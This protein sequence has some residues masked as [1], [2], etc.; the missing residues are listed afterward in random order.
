VKVLA[1]VTDYD[2]LHAVLRARK[3]ALDISCNTI[4][5]AACLTAA[6][7]SKLL[8]PQPLKRANWDTLAFLLPALGL[9]L[10]VLEDP[11]A[12]KQLKKFPT[13]QVKTPERSLPW[14]RKGK[15][16]RVSLRWQRRISSKGGAARAEKLTPAQRSAS[17]RKAAKARWR[18]P[19]ITEITR[20]PGRPPA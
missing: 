11:D 8:A 9:R 19:R 2:S 5:A 7:A 20:P 15:Q 14:G 6:H 18:K 13:R 4:D 12:I 3:E 1:V 10:A 17:A 16:M